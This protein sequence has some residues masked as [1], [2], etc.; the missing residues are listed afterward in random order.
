[1]YCCTVS[2]KPTLLFSNKTGLTRQSTLPPVQPGSPL[3]PRV[4]VSTGTLPCMFVPPPQPTRESPSRR[5]S[6][7]KS[8]LL[9]LLLLLMPGR[10]LP[11]TD[12]R[13]IPVSATRAA[14]GACSCRPVAPGERKRLACTGAEEG[15]CWG[16]HHHRGGHANAAESTAAHFGF[17]KSM[18]ECS[19]LWCQY[20]YAAGLA[21]GCAILKQIRQKVSR[22]G[23]PAW[24]PERI[25][26]ERNR[27]SEVVRVQKD[28][29]I[30][31]GRCGL[32][33]SSHPPPHVRICLF[34][35]LA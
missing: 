34:F 10:Q 13:R 33:L 3:H 31:D 4:T 6:Q 19:S 23:R 8:L 2:Y 5:S 7:P 22:F 25:H 9:L 30:Q 15:V 29:S 28:S 24:I 17:G 26:P 18:H 27:L 1:M 35:P 32:A 14:A 16:L 21:A 12:S 11:T 20:V